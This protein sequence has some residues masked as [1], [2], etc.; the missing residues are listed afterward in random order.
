MLRCPSSLH[1]GVLSSSVTSVTPT[2]RSHFNFNL[3]EGQELHS[4]VHRADQTCDQACFSTTTV[5]H[6]QRCKQLKSSVHTVEPGW[7][8]HVPFPGRRAAGRDSALSGLHNA[9]AGGVLRPGVLL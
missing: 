5:P 9:E 6:M 2:G 1:R 7:A 3:H 8:Q 4:V